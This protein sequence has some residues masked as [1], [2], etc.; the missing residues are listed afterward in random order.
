[1][2]AYLNDISTAVP[3]YDVHEAFI[4]YAENTLSARHFPIFHR[5]IERNQIEHR[6]SSL[7]PAEAGGNEG[8]A[9][10]GF[11]RPGGFPSTGPRMK[12][13]ER[14]APLLAIEAVGKLLKDRSPSEITHLI[15][16]TCTGFAAPG[17]DQRLI[18]HFGLSPSVERV[19]VGFMGCAAA[20][21]AL[22]VARH[23][24]R[25]ESKASVLVVAVE[26][27]TLH[28]QDNS[29]LEQLL[30]F[31]IFADGCAAAL[32]SDE[33]KGF[34]LD[35]F[36]SQIL[37]EAADLIRWGIGDQ[38]FDMLL[39]GR[40]PGAISNGLRENRPRISSAIN[41]QV[42]TWAVHPGGR[43]V[44]DAVE[45]SLS[46]TETALDHS[47]TV[48]RQ[49]GNMSSPTILFVLERLLLAPPSACDKGCALAFGPG[50]TIEAMNFTRV[51]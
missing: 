18:Q 2:P 7:E 25:A 32:V 23:I 1:M 11:F 12:V 13:Y 8:P 21:N 33:P 50:L 41:L 28:L 27:C 5:M 42:D 17:V 24:V 20:L 46:L 51:N 34:E 39:S 47:R 10:N 29:D 19:S 48:L 9:R 15:V 43:S 14:E 16:V 6:Y 26:L 30:C 40:V 45:Q 22:K 37:P 36:F 3:A 4:K 49:F 38:G 44:L 31:S 35:A